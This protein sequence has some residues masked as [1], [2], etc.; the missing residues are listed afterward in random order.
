MGSVGIPM[1]VLLQGGAKDE[2]PERR[3]CAHCSKPISKYDRPEKRY[4]S[5]ACKQ[6]AYRRRR[7]EAA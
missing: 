1:L 6:A 2:D 5:D 3:E 7:K 4:C